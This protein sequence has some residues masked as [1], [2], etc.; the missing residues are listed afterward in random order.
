MAPPPP[1]GEILLAIADRIEPKLRRAFLDAVAAA[2]DATV[3]R[4]VRDA[5]DRG[6][7][8]GAYHAIGWEG[9]AEPAL[10]GQFLTDWRAGFESAGAAT[11][12]RIIVPPPP[13]I[14]PPGMPGSPGGPPR[15]F[16]FE[17]LNPRPLR[18]LEQHGAD[19]VTEI[20]EP[21]REALRR[22]LVTMARL[23]W[24]TRTAATDIMGHIGL[25]ARLAQANINY[26]ARLLEEGLAATR[27]EALVARHATR[28]LRYRATVIARTES[29]YAIGN[30]KLM[31]W[32][33]AIDQGI[34]DPRVATVTWFTA[35]TE[36]VC[37]ICARMN[38][39]TIPLADL[40][41]GGGFRT[42]DGQI[43]TMPGETHPQC[44]CHMEMAQNGLLRGRLGDVVRIR[45]QQQAA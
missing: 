21:T 20:S 43:V 22:S 3:L 23:G 41:A 4:E 24:D 42:G 6:D 19:L 12:E 36:T 34:I 18:F 16:V 45:A 31:A 40:L 35:A 28:L 10:R 39:Q 25:T 33:Q 7:L 29:K 38:R 14:A 15:R 5:L 8:L 32:Q 9:H 2:R 1:E 11:A 26:R 44:E 30:G 17:V 13:P 27:I 37:P